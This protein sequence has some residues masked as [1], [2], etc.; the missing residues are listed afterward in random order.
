MFCPACGTDLADGARFCSSCGAPTQGQ[1]D[2]KN[3]P[4]SGDALH[5]PSSIADRLPSLVRTELSRLSPER[6]SQFVEEYR[7]K[8]KSV[9]MAYFL[10]FTI[11]LHYLY[12]NKVGTQLFYWFSFFGLLIWS[13]IDIFRIPGMVHDYNRDVATDVLRDMKILAN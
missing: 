10:W 2:Q 3:A 6:Q 5:I 12:L 8:S 13:I 11:G 7:R 1:Q 9:G 4:D